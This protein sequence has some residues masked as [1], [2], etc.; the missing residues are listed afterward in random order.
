MV[1][2]LIATIND[3]NVNRTVDEIRKTADGQV[4]FIV[5]ND[6]GTP[7]TL[8]GAT[9]IE[10]SEIMGRRVSFNQAARM[11]L[12][13]YLLIIDPHC[14]MSEH[15]DTYMKE[16]CGRDNLVFPVIR[17]IFPDTWQYRPGEYLHV[18]MNREYT[19]KWWFLR[20]WKLCQE[21]E[22]SM[23]FTGCGWMIARDRYWELGGYDESLGKYGWD[24]PEWSCKIWLS[25]NPGKVILHTKVICGHIFG[26]NIGGKL[27][28]CQM[29]PKKQYIDA[30]TQKWSAKVPSLIERFAPV[31]DWSDGQTPGRTQMSQ[32]T[33]REVKLQ[34]QKESVTRDEKGE[35]VR[36]VVTYYEYV[37]HD[38]GNGPD[39]KEILKQYADKLEPVGTEIWERK[40]GQLQKVA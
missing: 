5:V 17:D 29:I 4:E 20:P 24:G 8:P 12:G 32:G 10:H 38:D 6:G 26:T 40:D 31:P 22:E 15:W 2:V 30:M 27:Y 33:E 16:A 39:E 23:C 21:Q 11:A 9:V 25:D 18:S 28:R 36:K 35:I 37:Y 34:R 13:D 14:S 1:S 7:L 3:P 19:E